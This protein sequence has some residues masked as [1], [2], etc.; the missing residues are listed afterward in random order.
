MAKVSYKLYVG[1]GENPDFESQVE[2]HADFTALERF[3]SELMEGPSNSG[4]SRAMNAV[5]IVD[6]QP[7]SEHNRT[8]NETDN[9]A[10]QLALADK[11]LKLAVKPGLTP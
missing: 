4:P 11:H 9:Y 5:V 6:G 7:V 2:E 8:F 10:F 1:E 3:V